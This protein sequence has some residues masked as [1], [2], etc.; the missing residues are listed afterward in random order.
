MLTVTLLLS[1]PHR[2][3]MLETAF[4]SIPLDSWAVSEVL[5]RHQGGPW[6]WGGALRERILAEPKVRLVEFPDRVDFAQSFNRTVDAVQTPWALLLPDDDFLVRPAAKAAFEQAFSSPQLRDVGMLAFGWYYLKQ[7]R[8]LAN[9]FHRPSL[10]AVLSCTPKFCST[11]LNVAHVRELGGFA[12][13]GGF[14][15]ADLFGRLTYEFDAALIPSRVGVYR[16][17]D[18]QESQRI[19]A[20]Y[21]P[22][23][24]ALTRSLG[25]Y[26]RSPGEL[27]AFERALASFLAPRSNSRLQRLDELGFQLRSRARP[28]AKRRAFR[29]RKWSA[30]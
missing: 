3:A 10:S 26:A 20:V 30:G 11:A 1:G 5:V 29:I 17:H 16:M 4:D 25:R 28:S 7:G 24:G 15:D 22:H 8:Y 14:V 21:G 18:G 2:L 27:A 12:D 9:R 19:A 23:V 13:L 6:N